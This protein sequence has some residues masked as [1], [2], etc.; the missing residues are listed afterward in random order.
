MR[1]P[2]ACAVVLLCADL[3]A[4]QTFRGG[5][6]GT[7]I[8][9]TGAALPGATVVVTSTGTGLSRAVQTV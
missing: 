1:L 3:A 6:Q 5:I 7:V 8:D 9:Q 4:A 2:L